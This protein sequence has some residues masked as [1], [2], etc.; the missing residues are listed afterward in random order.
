MFSRK[1]FLDL[2]APSAHFEVLIH[3]IAWTSTSILYT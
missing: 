2:T 1:D 3:D